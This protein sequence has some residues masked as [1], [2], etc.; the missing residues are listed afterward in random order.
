MCSRSRFSGP[1]ARVGKR[2]LTTDEIAYARD[3]FVD[4]IDYTGI[5]ITRGSIFATGS[6]VTLGTT[7]HLKVGW[8]HFRGDGLELTERGKFTLIHEMTHVWQYQNGGLA[9]VPRSLLAQLRATLR[10]GDRGGAYDWRSAH[11]AQRPWARWNPEQQAEAVEDYNKLLRRS[12]A[13]ALSALEAADLDVLTQ[14]MRYVRNREGAP[15]WR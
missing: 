8:G 6:A 11:Q 14:Y 1:R 2:A 10:G 5:R 13:R 3:V 4:S 15:G 12:D 9:Y 7:I